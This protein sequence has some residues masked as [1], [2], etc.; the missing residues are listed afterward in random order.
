M[1][2][3]RYIL[4]TAPVGGVI[5]MARQVMTPAQLENPDVVFMLNQFLSEGDVPLEPVRSREFLPA[6]KK[7]GRRRATSSL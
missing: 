7:K 2:L 4:E 1:K 5:S 3:V 6:R